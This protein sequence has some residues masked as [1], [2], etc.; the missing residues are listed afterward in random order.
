MVASFDSKT[1][2][3]A[4]GVAWPSQI[5]LRVEHGSMTDAR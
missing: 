5:F 2:I 4:T 1:K 3:L